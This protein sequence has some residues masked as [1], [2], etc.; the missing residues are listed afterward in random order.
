MFKLI[1]WA[2]SKDIFFTYVIV[3]EFVCCRLRELYTYLLYWL[4]LNYA[5][6]CKFQNA[7]RPEVERE[8]ASY[9]QMSSDYPDFR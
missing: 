6:D 5:F 2:V 3:L 1:H 7:L 9:V 8:R 4:V